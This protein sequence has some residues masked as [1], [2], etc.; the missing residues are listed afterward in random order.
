MSVHGTGPSFMSWVV[1]GSGGR[2]LSFVGSCLRLWTVVFVFWPVVVTGCSWVVVGVG[3]HVVVAVGG[4]VQL[5]LWLVEG[6]SDV[7][8]CD[9]NV[10]FKLAHEIT[11]TISR[12]FLAVY[13][14]NPSG[15]VS[16]LLSLG[17]AHLPTSTSENHLSLAE[18][19]RNYRVTIKTSYLALLHK[20]MYNGPS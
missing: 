8:N 18:L 15:L 2:S 4:V 14:K 7:T 10:M 11:C 12:D 17:E 19:G 9:I 3:H 5:W 1:I 20:K 13:S 16:V 6:R